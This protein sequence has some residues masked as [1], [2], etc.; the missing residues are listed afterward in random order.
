MIRNIELHSR[1]KESSGIQ[2][3]HLLS[4]DIVVVVV[5]FVFSCVDVC[6]VTV[7]FEFI[8]KILES[9]N[10]EVIST[11]ACSCAGSAK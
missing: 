10:E 1:T 11:V 4:V 8:N 3:F 2:P 7:A 6:V 5:A 9:S